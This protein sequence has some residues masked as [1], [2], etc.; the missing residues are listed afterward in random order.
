VSDLVVFRMPPITIVSPSCTKTL[1]VASFVSIVGTPNTV[2][3]KSASFFVISIFIDIEPAGV[4]VGVTVRLKTASIKAVWVPSAE[5][6]RYGIFYPVL[7]MLFIIECR[8][9]RI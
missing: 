6:L 4:I 3:P 9:S 7:S 2:R 5:T 8:N 1:V